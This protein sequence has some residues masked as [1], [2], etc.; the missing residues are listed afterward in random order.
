[1]ASA[2]IEEPCV[3]VMNGWSAGSFECKIYNT[4]I[5]EKSAKPTTLFLKVK[6]KDK[7]AQRIN[8]FCVCVRVCVFLCDLGE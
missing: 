7:M 6:L 8:F 4:I 3:L 2:H 1:M 5:R